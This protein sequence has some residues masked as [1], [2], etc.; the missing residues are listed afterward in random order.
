[1]KERGIFIIFWAEIKGREKDS[2]DPSDKFDLQFP[3]EHRPAGEEIMKCL[4]IGVV[5]ASL[6]MAFAELQSAEVYTWTDENGNLHITQE[7]PPKKAKLKET[8]TYQPQ[9]AIKDS[10]TER[11][12]KAVDEAAAEKLKSTEL[13]KARAE[14]EQARKEAEI[15]EAQAEEAARMAKEYIETHNRNQYM[16]RA[17]QYQMEKAAA[18]AEAAQERAR[19]AEQRAIEAEKKA[20]LAQEQTQPASD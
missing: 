17:Y 15:A 4:I 20:R 5:I 8:M 14:A 6:F 10:E 7:P 11:R 19:L 12:Q 16:R 2:P 1:L 13:Q 3:G 18:D 9:P